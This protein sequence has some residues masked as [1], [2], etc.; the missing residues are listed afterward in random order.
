MQDGDGMIPQ[1]GNG[2]RTP[3]RSHS[4]ADEGARLL[5]LGRG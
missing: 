1:V 4:A 5:E 3:V 2:D